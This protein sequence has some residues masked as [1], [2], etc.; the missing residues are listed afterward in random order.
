MRRPRIL[1]VDLNNFARFPT[2]P[3]G[4]LVAILRGAGS[5]VSL[6]SPF[7]FG[8]PGF[9]REGRDAW[10]SLAD[11]RLRHWSAVT[12]FPGARRLRRWASERVGP[13]HAKQTKRIRSELEAHL[14]RGCDAVLVSAYTMYYDLCRAIGAACR[15]RGVPLL[16][17]GS[18][19]NQPETQEPWA[20]I[21]GVS[22]VVAGE[23]EAFLVELVDTLCSAERHRELESFPGVATARSPRVAPAPP[24]IE[25]DALPFPDYSD[26]P[27][28]AYPNRIVPMLTGRGCGWGRCT[29]C[30][31]V[32]S[33]MGRTFRSR[34]AESVLAELEHQAG[35][36]SA[37]LFVFSDL[38]L[39]SNLATWEA[40][41]AQVPRRVPGAAWTAAVHVG[42][43][44]ANGL[45]RA[46]LRDARAAG[47]VRVTTGLESGSQRILDSMKKGTRLERT[48]AFLREA[49]DAG[50]STR[51]TLIVG[52]PG[53]EP[54]DLHH[55]AVFLERNAP[56][57]DRVMLNRFT[58]QPGTPFHRDAE[59]GEVADA[60]FRLGAH[61]HR[62][63]VVAHERSE[64]AKRA[65]RGAVDRVLRAVH[66][67]NRSAL[68]GTARE[69]E[70][71]M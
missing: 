15:R 62:Q 69:F 54:V 33:A 26:F 66:A 2:L 3:V 58:V 42:T 16:V 55:T 41:L 43:E 67:I 39:N 19:L 20:L 31:D 34:S 38:K 48:Q 63:A 47:L 28:E 11:R 30:S 68:Q 60:G 14:D 29:F 25:L 10:W 61:D 46:A 53:E 49:R 50:I 71:V 40:L 57:I 9:A 13:T 59:Q 65:Q 1:L 18:Y 24:L 7:A 52:Y 4:L 37:R 27:W 8:V 21:P 6:L 70:G 51:V 64:T 22:G 17:G 12:R 56:A 44:K 32:T 5:E 36:C 35:R 45:D 23:P